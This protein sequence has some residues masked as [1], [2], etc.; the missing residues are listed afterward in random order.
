MV[1]NPAV[2]ATS[3]LLQLAK[4]VPNDRYNRSTFIPAKLNNPVC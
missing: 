1:V 4:E 3:L 2:S